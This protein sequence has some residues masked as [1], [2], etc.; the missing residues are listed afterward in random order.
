M[1]RRQ[2][3]LHRLMF[4]LLVLVLPAIIALAVQA[5]RWPPRATE[6]PA[7]LQQEPGVTAGAQR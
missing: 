3:R 5:R 6:I 1:N 7:F 2:R 4:L